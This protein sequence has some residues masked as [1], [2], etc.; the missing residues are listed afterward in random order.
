MPALLP[1]L[2]SVLMQSFPLSHQLSINAFDYNC[3]LELIKLLRQEGEL[4]RLRRARQKMSELFP[5]T[6]GRWLLPL[7]WSLR[8][9]LS[10][11]FASVEPS[12]VPACCRDL[13]G[14]AEGR[15]SDGCRDL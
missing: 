3:H 13:A 10:Y 2:A 7:T 11:L 6:E 14:L 1:V 4:V 12:P 5:L 15:D 9:V 8:P